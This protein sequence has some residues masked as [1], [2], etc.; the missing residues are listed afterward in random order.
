MWEPPCLGFAGWRGHT[1]AGRHVGVPAWACTSVGAETRALLGATWG[2]TG[3]GFRES[4]LKER[5]RQAGSSQPCPRPLARVLRAPG[6][7][8]EL[9]V[10]CLL[11]V[12]PPWCLWSPAG[13][14]G[15]TTLP[16]EDLGWP[17]QNQ[18]CSLISGICIGSSQCASW[19]GEH[20]HRWPGVAL[21][22]W[23][24][25]FWPSSCS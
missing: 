12:P 16:L 6:A 10:P 3:R 11:P 20:P 17:A 15:M 1:V 8:V 5:G 9:R 14:Q 21:S 4:R 18:P 2:L 13:A 7:G 24:W 25:D 22:P 23:S 19:S